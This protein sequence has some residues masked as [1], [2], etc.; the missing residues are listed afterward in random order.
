MGSEHVNHYLEYRDSKLGNF[1]NKCSK[2]MI[3]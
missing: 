3:D 2:E 1:G